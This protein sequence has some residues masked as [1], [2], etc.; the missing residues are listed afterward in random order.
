M[1]SCRWRGR[2]GVAWAVAAGVLLLPG[3]ARAKPGTHSVGVATWDTR[4]SSVSLAGLGGWREDGTST[5]L[6]YWANFTSTSGILSSQFGAH[7]VGLKEGS[8]NFYGVSASGTAVFDWAVVRRYDNGI[9]RVGIGWSLG[10]APA[11][12]IGGDF[13]YFT[14]PL[15]TGLGVP[16]SPV[17]FVTITPWGEI[18]PSL[19]L[20]THFDPFSIDPLDYTDLYNSQTGEIDFDAQTAS[21]LF[22][23]SVSLELGG[24]FS[25]RGGVTIEVHLGERTS[26]S[27]RGG[28]ATVGDWAERDVLLYAGGGFLWRWDRIV[29]AVLPAWRRLADEDCEAVAERHRACT[30]RSSPDAPAAA[31][32]PTTLPP[33]VGAGPSETQPVRPAPARPGAAPPPIGAGPSETQPWRPAP[34]TQPPAARPP[35]PRPPP[36]AAS[37]PATPPP[38]VPPRA[39]P[40]APAPPSPAPPPAAPPP[41]PAPPPAA[42]PAPPPPPA[43]PAPPPPPTAP[44]P[45]PVPS[46]P[47]GPPT[48]SF[49]LPPP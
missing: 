15:V 27:L 21:S 5:Q 36:P 35:S 23:D 49:P 6:S 18:A 12:L 41:A 11:A 37:P 3:V 22:Q 9:P 13:N 40:V 1:E 29:P 34:G 16:L 17:E 31:P 26:L 24:G 30:L 42:P 46:P 28:V 25:T 8:R 10:S 45:P 14:L 2:T 47:A 32:A 43:A 48:E 44:A 33:P 39:P 7:Y 19:N 4:A 20:D 38:A